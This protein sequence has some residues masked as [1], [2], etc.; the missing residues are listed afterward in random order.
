VARWASVIVGGFDAA[1]ESA[2]VHAT[3]S[4][5][6]VRAGVEDATRSRSMASARS[7][8][9]AV[10]VMEPISKRVRAVG[11][12]PVESTAPNPWTAEVSGRSRPI[13]AP[14]GWPSTR[15]RPRESTGAGWAVPERGSP[16]RRTHRSTEGRM[17][18]AGGTAIAA[19][20]VEGSD[21][22]RVS[23]TVESSL[24]VEGIPMTKVQFAQSAGGL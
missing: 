1:T 12:A 5:S 13:T 11:D 18:G 23:L 19:E 22:T 15:A 20:T 6:R 17:E 3:E 14:P 4:G 8:P 10:F 9:V 21:R 7:N 24:I 2:T 16:R